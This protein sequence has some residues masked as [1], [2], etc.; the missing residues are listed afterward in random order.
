MK[1]I[2]ELSTEQM[3]VLRAIVTI[4]AEDGPADD[5][6]LYAN[7]EKGR[8]KPLLTPRQWEAVYTQGNLDAI[9]RELEKHAGPHK[10]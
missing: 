5:G 6:L 1:Y 9:R 4:Q 8:N 2:L 3:Y 7:P 10:F